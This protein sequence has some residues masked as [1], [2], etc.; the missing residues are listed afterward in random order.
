[1]NDKTFD[2]F[3][4]YVCNRVFRWYPGISGKT[5][6]CKCG[7]KV[8][9]PELQSGSMTAGESLDDTVADVVL[10]EVLDDFQP[11]SADNIDEM[12]AIH[13]SNVH[14][15]RGVFGLTLGG[16]VLFFGATSI[17][18]LAFTILCI[19][20]VIWE[21]ANMRNFWPYLVVAVIVGPA[22]WKLFANRWR[23]YSRGRSVPRVIAELFGDEAAG[24]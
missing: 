9:C 16:E 24:G 7:A 3:Q 20:T 15:Y 22:S 1:M 23:L 14:R 2:T 5:I 10:D 17:V 19:V 18:G 6:E 4:C 21:K 11:G 8:R 13:L 12:E